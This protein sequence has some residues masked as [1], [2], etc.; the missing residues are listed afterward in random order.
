MGQLKIMRNNTVSFA[1]LLS[2]LN[3]ISIQTRVDRKVYYHSYGKK[4]NK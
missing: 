4:T 1:Y 3:N 2:A